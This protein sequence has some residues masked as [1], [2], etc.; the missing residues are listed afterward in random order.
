VE[1]GAHGGH[2]EVELQV[3]RVVPREGGDAVAGAD[4]E[5]REGVREA[6]RARVPLAPR[7]SDR[8]GRRETLS[9]RGAYRAERSRRCVIVRGT[10]I[11]DARMVGDDIAI[12]R[13]GV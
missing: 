12:A 3:A 5:L 10:F 13:V 4:A 6:A 8:S 2:G 9:R 7:W 11:M 1:H